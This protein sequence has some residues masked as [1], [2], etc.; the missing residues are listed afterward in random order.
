MFLSV[1]VPLWQNDFSPQRRGEIWTEISDGRELVTCS[2]MDPIEENA[3]TQP[4]AQ[5]WS[6][7][8]RAVLIVVLLACTFSCDQISKN[9]ARTK[10]HSYEEIKVIP[11][12]VT[13]LRVENSGSFL[14]LGNSLSSPVRFVLLTML[15]LIA[16]VG[17]LVVLILRKDISPT[18][19]VGFCFVIGGG[20]GNIYDRILHGS[21]TDFLFLKAG[22][23]QTGV[24]NMADVSVTTGVIILLI[25]SWFNK[26]K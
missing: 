12:H 25:Q 26:T 19:L 7:S 21:V 18:S 8:A 5:P 9:L 17:G 13:L 1:F 3:Q 20:M 2:R 6:R 11:D 22:F 23:L 24:F 15:P 10:I 14:S 4:A 16:L